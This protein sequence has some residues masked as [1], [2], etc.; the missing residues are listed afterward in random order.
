M[1]KEQSVTVTLRV[2]ETIR[3]LL[4]AAAEKDHRSMA[5]MLEVLILRHCEA[6]GISVTPRRAKRKT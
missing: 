5:N 4:R 3:E 6:S 1:A 2:P